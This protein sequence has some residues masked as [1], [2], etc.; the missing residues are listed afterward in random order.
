MTTNPIST[1]LTEAEKRHSMRAIFASLCDLGFVKT[2][3]P[4]RSTWLLTLLLAGSLSLAAQTNSTNALTSTNITTASTSE[5]EHKP[6]ATSAPGKLD[7][8]SFKIISERNIFN[9]NRSGQRISTTRSSTK[10]ISVQVE[11]FTLVGTLLADEKAP[12]AFFDG[13]SSELRKAL[14]AGGNIAGFTVKEILQA[15]VRVNQGTNMIDLFVGSGMRREDRGPWKYST[16]GGSYASVSS[17]RSSSSSSSEEDRSGNSS[18][19]SSR[20]SSSRDRSYS[21]RGSNGESSSSASSG[22]TSSAPADAAEILK[23]LMEKREKE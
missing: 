7:Y 10:Q 21:R 9:G 5:S 4:G 20:D 3:R 19:Y 22:S 18:R 6:A 2:L 23:R 16:A 15:G 8:S 13:T 1:R 14:K 17:S 11:S 12:V